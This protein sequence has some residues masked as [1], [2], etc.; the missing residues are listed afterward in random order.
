MH[1][2]VFLVATVIP[3][4][5]IVVMRAVSRRLASLDL[6]EP[7]LSSLNE[8]NSP[9]P[10]LLGEEW[11]L[12]FRDEGGARFGSLDRHNCQDFCS[13]GSSAALTFRRFAPALSLRTCEIPIEDFLDL[14]RPNRLC[15]IPIHSCGEASLLITL[16]CMSG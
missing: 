4:D 5:L 3:I 7:N 1:T 10:R 14:R 11:M 13:T 9:K 8:L 12:L 16:H 2:L 15:E 6:A